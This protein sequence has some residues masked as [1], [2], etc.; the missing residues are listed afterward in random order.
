MSVSERKVAKL[1][2]AAIRVLEELCTIARL[3]AGKVYPSY[4][5]LA[6][7]TALGRG[8]VARVLNILDD[9]GLLVR[10]RRF[11]KIKADAGT[12]RYQQTSNAYRLTFPANLLGYLPRWLKPAPLPDDETQRAVDR[13]VDQA[14]MLS[15][16][17]SQDLARAIV[18][19]GPLADVL[20]KLGSSIDAQTA[21][22]VTVPN[23]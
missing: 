19:G 6:D 1:T 11:A 22:T 17:N 4:E 16:L 12:P 13:Q 3:C 2:P 23:R 21:S 5:H 10:Q 7:A 18:G 9:V 8:T 20:A 15:Q 14:H